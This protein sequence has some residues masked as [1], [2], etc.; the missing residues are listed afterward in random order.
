MS[1]QNKIQRTKKRAKQHNL[2]HMILAIFLAISVW[3]IV[4]MTQYPSV[5]K[6]I[7]HIPLS[8][9]ITDTAAAA[10]GL[11]VISCDVDEVTVELLGSR[12]Q[13]GN[14]NNENIEAYIDADS[15]ST[16]GTKNLTVRIKGGRGV[17]FEVKSITP[18]T[19]NV[20]F[21]KYDTREFD[22]KPKIPNVSF[23]EGKAI[24]PDEFTCD[25]AVVRINGPSSTLDKI[26]KCLS[27][28]H[29]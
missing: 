3:F 19:A 10:N 18:E 14:L 28:I 26:S 17:N 7:T 27:L 1:S 24:D 22:V 8:I 23:T 9:D 16:T 12:T 13:V 20:V 15:V 5:P 21:D 4:S 6:T 2:P 25:P 11:S 29:I